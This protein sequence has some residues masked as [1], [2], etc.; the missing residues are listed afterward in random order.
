MSILYVYV[1]FKGCEKIKKKS[2]IRSLFPFLYD[3]RIIDGGCKVNFL[4]IRQA[5]V[6]CRLEERQLDGQDRVVE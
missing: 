6:I 4:F 5:R 3:D 1:L 2:G